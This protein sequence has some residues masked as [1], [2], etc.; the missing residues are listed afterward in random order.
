ML[1]CG[2]EEAIALKTLSCR[3]CCMV[4]DGNLTFGGDHFV[5]YTD[6]ELYNVVH[7]K[8]VPC[9]IPILPQ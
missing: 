5:V 8:L 2:N 4:M 7:P 6:V 9:Y 3:V 1:T